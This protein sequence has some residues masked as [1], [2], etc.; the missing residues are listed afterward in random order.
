MDH[1][2]LVDQ[3]YEAYASRDA[4]AAASL[5]HADGWHEEVAMGKRREGHSAL[6]KGLT[7]FWRMLPDVAWERRGYI[8]A[9]N[10]IAVPYHM[11]G[12]FT[13]RAENTTPRKIA[14]DGLHIFEVSDGLLTG[15]KDMWDLDLFK[16]Q[17]G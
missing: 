14:L 2:T 1:A 3:F 12:T 15:T 5:Y 6:S 10:Q 9:G 13:P 7:G 8:R 11:T 16:A 17:M 4:E